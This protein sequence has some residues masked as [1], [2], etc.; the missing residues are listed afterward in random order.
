MRMVIG[1]GGL[2]GAALVLAWVGQVQARTATRSGNG[3][4]L[5]VVVA[6]LFTSEGC[7]SCPPADDLL[8]RLSAGDLASEVQVIALGEHVD[9]WDRLGWRGGVSSSVFSARPSAYG[10]A[11]LRHGGLY[12]PPL[13]R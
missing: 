9:Y 13:V 5:P 10:S 7:S 12:T 6:E 2:A 11:G 4:G 1:I 3:A 8:R